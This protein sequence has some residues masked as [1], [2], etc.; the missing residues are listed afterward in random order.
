MRRENKSLP[1]VNSFVPEDKEKSYMSED[2]KVSYFIELT[3]KIAN[4]T[5][6]DFKPTQSPGESLGKRL[7]QKRDVLSPTIKELA[8]DEKLSPEQAREIASA[9]RKLAANKD[10]VEFDKAKCLA[11]AEK[12]EAY[13]I[14]RAETKEAVE[15]FIVI[16][17]EMGSFYEEHKNENPIPDF[18]NKDT[19]DKYRAAIDKYMQKRLL[20]GEESY[21]IAKVYNEQKN[22]F[23]DIKHI[24]TRINEQITYAS[25]MNFNFK[26]PKGTP[27]EISKV[28]SGYFA[29]S[30]DLHSFMKTGLQK[31][32]SDYKAIKQINKQEITEKNLE[33]YKK[34]MK[35][36][37]LLPSEKDEGI[38]RFIQFQEIANN[39]SRGDSGKEV[40]DQLARFYLSEMEHKGKETNLLKMIREDVLNPVISKLYLQDPIVKASVDFEVGK[41]LKDRQDRGITS[42]V[43]NKITFFIKEQEPHWLT[44]VLTTPGVLD[45]PKED[46]SMDIHPL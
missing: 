30:E 41:Q 3:N 37:K 19:R 44:R 16:M 25:Q 1:A 23:K 17:K 13:A 8:K 4:L 42:P 31:V 21:E 45:V 29:K 22:M 26:E 34:K 28:K 35:E 15:K 43:E 27:S 2:K 39:L 38:E 14:R 46:K 18:P 10:A 24:E 7:M 40:F 5:S 11:N 32:I 33:A 9:Y 12:L 20:S 36:K 6:E